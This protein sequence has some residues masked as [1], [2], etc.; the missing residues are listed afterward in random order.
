MP[1]TMQNKCA[2]QTNKYVRILWESNEFKQLGMMAESGSG[3]CFQL[4]IQDD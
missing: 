4:N 1:S 3:S 2:I